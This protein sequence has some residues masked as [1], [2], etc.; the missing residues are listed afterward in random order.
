MRIPQGAGVRGGLIAGAL[1]A[2]LLAGCGGQNGRGTAPEGAPQRIIC[3]TPAV[4]EIVYALGCGDRIV[5]VSEFADWPP[6]AAQKPVIGG[7]LAPNREKIL[8]LKPDWILAQGR[9]EVLGSFAKAQG[10]G[11]ASLPL[12][13]LAD[14]RAMITGFAAALGVEDRGRKLLA[15]MDAAFAAIPVSG[16][17]PVFLA[18]GH[19]PGDFSGLMTSGPGTF[20]SEI[21]EKAGGSNVFADV[22]ALWPKISQETL[23]RRAPAVI[24]DF[25]TA[26]ADAA[27]RAAL[28]ADWEKLGFEPGQVRILEEDYLLK[29]GPRAA[30]SAARMAAALAGKP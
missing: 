11:F 24:L 15:D 26:P 14:L 1:A 13:T 22:K 18:L 21:V 5:G 29:P 6:E 20:L 25:Q 30:R 8:A 27:R 12:D 17:T 10:I 19:V 9:S 7:A 2:L 4:T 3:A 28:T 16:T 23:I